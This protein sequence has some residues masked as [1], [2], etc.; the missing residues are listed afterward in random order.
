[1][2]TSKN[3]LP[4]FVLFSIPRIPHNQIEPKHATVVF[5]ILSFRKKSSIFRLYL[6]ITLFKTKSVVKFVL[7]KL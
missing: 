2:F 3:I 6:L 7:K 4:F 5:I 1:M